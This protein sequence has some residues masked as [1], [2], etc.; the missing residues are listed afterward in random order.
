MS[1]YAKK[2]RKKKERKR[3]KKRKKIDLIIELNIPTQDF[4]FRVYLLP[5]KNTNMHKSL[6]YSF[7]Q[8][9]FSMYSDEMWTRS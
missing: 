6:S 3:K 7:V 4:L 9:G 5:Q 8:S 2:K 1:A